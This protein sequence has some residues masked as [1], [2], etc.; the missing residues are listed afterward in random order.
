MVHTLT[1]TRQSRSS[2]V[3]HPGHTVPST[4]KTRSTSSRLAAMV[5][6]IALLLS[7]WR[8]G[9]NMPVP[10]SLSFRLFSV[11]TV[12]LSPGFFGSG[13]SSNMPVPLSLLFRPFSVEWLVMTPGFSG[14]GTGSKM[15]V[16]V[17]LLF[18]P[19]S[20][21][22]LIISPGFSGSSTSS[23]MPVPLSLWFCP[24]CDRFA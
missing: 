3:L 20:V 1:L 19:A 16:F 8:S 13:T 18:R 4:I 7:S 6:L 15:A 2:A 14:S 21:W 24:V 5:L 9:S 12:I 17:S 10:S 22:W 23:N 11:A